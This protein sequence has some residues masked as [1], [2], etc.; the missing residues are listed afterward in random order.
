MDWI[1]I[2][3]MG[4]TQGRSLARERRNSVQRLPDR[5][6]DRRRQQKTSSIVGGIV[7]FTEYCIGMLRFGFR[8]KLRPMDNWGFFFG[9]GVEFKKCGQK[10]EHLP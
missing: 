8:K 4:K 9:Y 5:R 7:P 1:D 2:K 6:G 3:K 10:N